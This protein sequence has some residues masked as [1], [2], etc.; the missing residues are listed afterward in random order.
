MARLNHPYADT[1]VAA[2]NKAW[3]DGK[4]VRDGL[5][6]HAEKRTMRKVAAE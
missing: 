1:L 2:R 3:D 5:L 6:A 4:W